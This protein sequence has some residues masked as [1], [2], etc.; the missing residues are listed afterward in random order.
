MTV[1][2]PQRARTLKPERTYVPDRLL[3][4]AV[5]FLWM[6]VWRFQELWPLLGKIRLSLVLELALVVALLADN[7]AIRGWH[8]VKSKLFVL[9]FVLLAIMVIGLPTNL[10]PGWALTFITKDF[11]PTL[12][13]MAA[14]ARSPRD[15]R[16]LDWVAFAHLVGATVYASW[17]FTF[18]SVGA[19]GRL[20]SLIYY[21][22]N[23]FGLL[24]DC[25][26]PFAV[27]FARPGVSAPKRIFAIGALALFTAMLIKSGSRG[28]FLGFVAVMAFMAITFRAIPGRIRY[29]A[30]AVGLVVLVGLGS[31]KY[32]AMMQTILH[33]STDYNLT[34]DTGRKAVWKRGIGY[35]LTHPITGVGAAAFGQAEGQLSETAREYAAEGHGIKWSTAHN[36]FVLVGAELGVGGL[37]VFTAML[38]VAFSQLNRIRRSTRGSP[39]RITADDGAFAQ[40]LTAS[41]GGYCVAGFFVSAAYFSYLYVLIGLTIAQA[42]VLRRRLAMRHRELAV[43]PPGLAR[44]AEP[45]LT[46]IGDGRRRARPWYP[47]GPA[48]TPA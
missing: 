33:P 16:D 32:W 10:W 14:L 3:V 5:A 7:S 36:S 21:D 13:L 44:R 37:V 12:V 41:L 4:V 46:P 35:M 22:A 8:W 40:M 2:L 45:V 24:L 29:G 20:A 48:S 26:I 42:A 23:D 43:A 11:G 18:F 30:I 9:P 31:S 28:G 27:Y 6:S 34:A 15:R 1:A 17:V 19:D 47:G 38:L 25:T 39:L